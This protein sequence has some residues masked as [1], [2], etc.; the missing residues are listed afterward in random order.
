MIRQDR[1]KLLDDD[2]LNLLENGDDSDIE[3]FANGDDL[4]NNY[5]HEDLKLFEG[6]LCFILNY[7][8]FYYIL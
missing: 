1:R 6:N 5:C 3:E 8:T 7:V 4:G 2:I